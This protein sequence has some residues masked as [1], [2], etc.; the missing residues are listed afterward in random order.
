M[1]NNSTFLNS[2]KILTKFY[3]T[4]IFHFK[5]SHIWIQISHDFCL[6]K[7]N[8]KIIKPILLINHARRKRKTKVVVETNN[9]PE[10]T[11]IQ[12]LYVHMI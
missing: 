12:K 10:A 4:F 5:P 6:V 7:K 11:S 9:E 2:K 8:K 1:I 3:S